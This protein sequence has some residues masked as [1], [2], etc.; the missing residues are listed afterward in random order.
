MWTCDVKN[1]SLL[2][3]LV[4]ASLFIC[5]SYCLLVC[6]IVILPFPNSLFLKCFE[7]CGFVKYSNREMA[8]AAINALSGKF[9]MR[10]SSLSFHQLS[11]CYTAIVWALILFRLV[12]AP[13]S[14]NNLL[15]NTRD[16][17]SH[18]LFDLLTLRG[19]ELES[20]G[21][22]FYFSHCF[23]FRSNDRTP[24]FLKPVVFL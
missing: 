17:I 14:I 19:L 4:F 16:V 23:H 10:V 13:E 5:F 3:I 1:P 9:T 22:S 21:W 6:A 18:W 7:G 11:V 24:V 20:Q 15:L 2:F 8:L 12:F